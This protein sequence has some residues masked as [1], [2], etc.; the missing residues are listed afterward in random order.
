MKD[1]FAILGTALLVTLPRV[2]ACVGCRAP[3][4]GGAEEPKTVT[5]GIAFSLS[6]ISLLVLVLLVLAGLTAYIAKTCQ[7]LDS[8]KNPS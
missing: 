2:N 1:Y 8:E 3:G 5:S 7:R 6:V 4:V